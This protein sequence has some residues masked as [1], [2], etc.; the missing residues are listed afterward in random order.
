MADGVRAL[1]L[2]VGNAELRAQIDIGKLH[3]GDALRPHMLHARWHDS[4]ADRSGDQIDRGR[5]LRRLL[6][7]ARLESGAAAGGDDRVG[8]SRSLSPRI[9]DEAFAGEF[10][11]RDRLFPCQA[12]AERDRGHHRVARERFELDRAAGRDR[13]TDEAGVQSSLAQSFD[14]DFGMRFL[15]LELDTRPFRAE[16]RE[17]PGEYGAEGRRLREAD[18]QASDVAAR[19]LTRQYRRTLDMR[20]DRLRLGLRRPASVK[21]TPRPARANSFRPS[22]ASNALICCVSGGCAIPRRSA[23]RWMCISSAATQK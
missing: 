23:A 22:S 11:Q 21:A 8:K 14:L 7:D 12:M 4:D 6:H 3:K 17:C 19:D 16:R 5:Q 20:E 9:A 15:Q 13:W 2:H 10:F 1:G 18:A